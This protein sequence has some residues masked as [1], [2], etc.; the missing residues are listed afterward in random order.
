[1]ASMT[2]I[3][4]PFN[5]A[6]LRSWRCALRHS[7]LTGVAPDGGGTILASAVVMVEW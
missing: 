5:A 7:A 4:E 3:M 2:P 1:M 6:T